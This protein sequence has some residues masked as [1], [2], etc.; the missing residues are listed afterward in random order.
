MI[1]KKMFTGKQTC[2][3]EAHL[4]HKVGQQQHINHKIV[5]VLNLNIIFKNCRLSYPRRIVCVKKIPQK[6]PNV[7]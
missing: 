6:L 1:Q 2:R 4:N 5:C 3:F 7:F